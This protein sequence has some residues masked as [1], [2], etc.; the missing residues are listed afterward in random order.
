MCTLAGSRVSWSAAGRARSVPSRPAQTISSLSLSALIRRTSTVS[1]A[2]T[3]APVAVTS[4][5]LAVGRASPP[6]SISASTLRRFDAPCCSTASTASTALVACIPFALS[7]FFVIPW[8]H[9]ARFSS[10]RISDQAR[11]ATMLMSLLN[12]C[13][14]LRNTGARVSAPLLSFLRALGVLVGSAKRMLVELSE[15]ST[16]PSGTARA[17]PGAVGSTAVDILAQGRMARDG[18]QGGG[19]GLERRRAASRSRRIVEI[20]Q[21][22]QTRPALAPLVP[23]RSCAL[24]GVRTTHLIERWTRA[25]VA[26][27]ERIE[28][29]PP[30]SSGRTFTADDDPD[31]QIQCSAVRSTLA[32]NERSLHDRAAEDFFFRA[33]EPSLP[34]VRRETRLKSIPAS[35]P[36]LLRIAPTP[37][38]ATPRRVV[39]SRTGSPPASVKPSMALSLPPH[40]ILTIALCNRSRQRS[41]GPLERGR[42]RTAF[43]SP[44]PVWSL[45]GLHRP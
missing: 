38:I 35:P 28:V 22:Q 40:R 24:V 37:A 7:S 10:C 45:L 21:S 25:A 2:A 14:G 27:M 6:D 15:W 3:F 34:L 5:A 42:G 17:A 36:K 1:T 13:T 19:T 9:C 23:P 30:P 11:M 16:Y 29:R 4:S 43:E 26:G 20:G 8:V 33:T 18:S 44:P 39:S 32:A 41:L 31:H 12:C